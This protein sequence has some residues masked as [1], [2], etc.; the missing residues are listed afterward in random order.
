[1]QCAESGLVVNAGGGFFSRAAVASAPVVQ[2]GDGQQ[3]PTVEEIHRH[4]AEIDS[5][6]SSRQYQDANAMLMDMLA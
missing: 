2:V 3:A 1:E 5:L 4:W 6:E